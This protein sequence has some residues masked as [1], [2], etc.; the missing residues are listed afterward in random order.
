MEK[1][2]KTTLQGLYSVVVLTPPVIAYAEKHKGARQQIAVWN[3]A[4]AYQFV[5]LTN[6]T[7]I[8][9]GEIGHL[10]RTFNAASV[11]GNGG[12]EQKVLAE[13]ENTGVDIAAI[14]LGDYQKIEF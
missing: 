9:G 6:S 5:A 10:S 2:I 8:V 3:E 13:G 11:D 12:G 4:K 7:V 1:T 14:N